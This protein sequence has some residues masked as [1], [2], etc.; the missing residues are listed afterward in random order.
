MKHILFLSRWYPTVK[1]PDLGTFVHK[2]AQ[3][4]AVHHKV[5]LI[6]IYRSD[7][8]AV[9]VFQEGNLR[10]KR[11]GFGSAGI[12]PDALYRLWLYLKEMRQLHGVEKI[13]LVHANVFN[14]PAL[15]A[16]LFKKRHKIPFLVTEHW[17]GYCNGLFDAQN[18]VTKNLTRFLARKAEIL[19]P[20]SQFLCEHMKKCGLKGNYQVLGNV[21]DIPEIEN[22]P[23]KKINDRFRFLVV[24]DLIDAK[25]NVSGVI[26]AFHRI[27]QEKK[28]LHLDIVGEGKDRLQLENQVKTMNLD[29]QVSFK[30]KLAHDATIRYIRNAHCVVVNS[31]IETFS[32]VT[33]EAIA[34]GVPVIGTACGGPEFIIEDGKTGWVI[35]KKSNSQLTHKMLTAVEKV[36]NMNQQYMAESIEKRY[37]PQTIA[38]KL[39]QIYLKIVNE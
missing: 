16:Y 30:G 38:T 4:A 18:S 28:N 13:D 29:K 10:V 6:Y 37:S 36:G 35:P 26:Q 17:T 14:S 1:Q 22:V 3:A 19:L 5:S 21:I 7:E 12:L 20:V 34:A 25:K 9:E 27:S 8:D 2:H 24:A 15:L 31:N 23:S 39:N 33:A 32:V 11:I